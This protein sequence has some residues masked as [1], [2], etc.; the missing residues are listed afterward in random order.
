MLSLVTMRELENLM[1]K[2]LHRSAQRRG[3]IFHDGLISRI[4]YCTPNMITT[5]LLI[6]VL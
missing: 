3:G 6:F 2:I 1:V 5:S 4:P